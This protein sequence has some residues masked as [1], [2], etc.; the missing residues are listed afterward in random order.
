MSTNLGILFPFLPLIPTH[1]TFNSPC[2]LRQ[3]SSVP[4]YSTVFISCL[5]LIW[6]W[7][8]SVQWAYLSFFQSHRN[9]TDYS[10]VSRS[11]SSK[12]KT[13]RKIL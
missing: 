1:R 9:G 3:M 13:M 4:L 10:N 12:T 6:C 7:P 2:V 8:A 5:F 11:K